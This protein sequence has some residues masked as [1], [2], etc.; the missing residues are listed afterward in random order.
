MHELRKTDNYTTITTILGCI[1]REGWKVFGSDVETQNLASKVLYW[2]DLLMLS[3]CRL[4]HGRAARYTMAR[5]Q[6]Y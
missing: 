2:I 5:K 1:K 3:I 6:S 4:C